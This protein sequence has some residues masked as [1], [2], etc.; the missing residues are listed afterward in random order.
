MLNDIKI[1]SL[2]YSWAKKRPNLKERNLIERSNIDAS[3]QDP[4]Q[5]DSDHYIKKKL[6]FTRS[7]EHTNRTSNENMV[8]MSDLEERRQ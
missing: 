8:T 7:S 6:T 3:E 4:N 2:S 5:F 1:E